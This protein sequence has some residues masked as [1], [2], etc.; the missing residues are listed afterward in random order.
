MEIKGCPV[1]WGKG[2]ICV[3][4]DRYTL[5]PI[6]EPCMGCDGT[7]YLVYVDKEGK[8][9]FNDQHKVIVGTLNNDEARAFIKFLESEIIRH[10]DDINQAKSLIGYVKKE[11][12]DE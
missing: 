1:C 8:M 7:G 3:A 10:K 12:L 6:L 5:E 9:I 2:A 11:I 4:I